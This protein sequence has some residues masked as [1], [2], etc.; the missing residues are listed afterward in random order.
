MSPRFELRDAPK[1]N[2]VLIVD[3]YS[4]NPGPVSIACSLSCTRFGR[5]I[6]TFLE[7][8]VVMV[9]KILPQNP[10]TANRNLLMPRNYPC[11]SS[12]TM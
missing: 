12:A 4:Q 9:K 1:Q 8:T 6:S 2:R 10:D 11:A 3:E 5:T 7:S